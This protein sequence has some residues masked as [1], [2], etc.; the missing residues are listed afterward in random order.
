MPDA[1][2]G[3]WMRIGERPDQDAVDHSEDRR[4]CTDSQGERQQN[5]GGKRGSPSQ[6]TQG[7]ARIA[8]ERFHKGKSSLIS[9]GFLDGF[10]AAKLQQ[11]LSASFDGREAGSKILG[12]LHRNVLF[13]FSAQSF[14]VSSERRP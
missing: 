13:E 3:L 6:T 1:H 12:G 2:Q 10:H 4:V 14:L 8:Q 5:G 9:I 7:V 11:R